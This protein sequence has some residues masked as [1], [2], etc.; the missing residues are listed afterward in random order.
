[1]LLEGTGSHSSRFGVIARLGAALAGRVGLGDAG[2]A[3]GQQTGPDVPCIAGVVMP[4]AG[5]TKRL[6]PFG[7]TF[8]A[9]DFN[10][11]GEG[12]ELHPLSAGCVLK[13][14]VGH[15]WWVGVAVSGASAPVT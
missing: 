2:P 6:R 11:V 8:P 5:I 4:A 3:L 7:E 9:L 12:Q 15:G 10:R 13:D 14:R 1:M